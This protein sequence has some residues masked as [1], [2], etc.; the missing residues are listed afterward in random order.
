MS[1]FWVYENWRAHGPQSRLHTG[2]C[3]Y[4]NHGHGVSTG[5]RADNG[6]WHGPF[7]MYTEAANV[8]ERLPGESNACRICRPTS[9]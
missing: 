6:K 1:D 2:E 9:T 7:T 5:T 3:H 4:C 8:S